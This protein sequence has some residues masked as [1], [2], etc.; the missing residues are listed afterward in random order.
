M[1]A[2]F[3]LGSLEH[4]ASY[5]VHAVLDLWDVVLQSIYGDDAFK[6]W[7]SRGNSPRS[8]TNGDSDTI[9]YE[10]TLRCRNNTFLVICRYIEVI[11][12]LPTSDDEISCNILVSLPP[13]YPGSAAPQLQLLSKYIGPFG[14]DSTLFGA[15]LRTFIS[16]GGVEYVTDSVCVFD[17]LE[18]VK[19]RCAEWYHAKKSEKLAGQLLREDERGSSTPDVEE[20]KNKKVSELHDLA[21]EN[22]TSLAVSIPKGIEI[23]ESEP[24]LDRKSAFIGRACQITDPS[25]VYQLKHRHPS[26]Y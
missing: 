21:D 15:V 2:A 10:V 5:A 8:D 9:R 17:G 1:R 13:N 6:L 26:H 20:D 14:V 18:W 4:C 11:Y 24:I 22:A 3:R 16:S 25:Q 7:P 19:E 23:I 12:S